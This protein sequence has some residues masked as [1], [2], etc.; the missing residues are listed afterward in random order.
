M[1]P[2]QRAAVFLKSYIGDAVMAQPI[3]APLDR[4][5]RDVK[6]VTS[7]VIDQV[8]FDPQHPREFL[9]LPRVRRF[10]EV[11]RQ[12]LFLRPYQ[13]EVAI[14]VN[15]SF[16]SAL[17]ARLA[18]I[19]I[20]VGHPEDGRR[21]LLTTSVPYSESDN[22]TVSY[23]DLIRVIGIDDAIELPRLWVS[24]EERARGR[25]FLAGARV[26]LQPGARFAAKRIPFEVT[27]EI[28]DSLDQAGIRSAFLGG[29]D[30]IASAEET[31]RLQRQ[32]SV[33]LVGRT[34]IRESLGVLS[35]LDLMVGSDTGLMHMAAAVHC[36][37]ITV[38]GPT[39]I[40]KWGHH[41]EPHVAVQAPE[42]VISN[43]RRELIWPHISRRLPV[44]LQTE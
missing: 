13:F 23:T 44:P 42:R 1:A 12:A 26:G 32:P 5:F 9:K 33:N 7:G 37:T 43:A 29:P 27:A 11:I 14:L 41:Y 2:R 31:I 17:T 35:N 38:F 19:K 39:P 30:E 15:H 10:A 4:H 21:A 36:P 18:G 16:R 8:L 34:S 28:A 24:S 22:E 25:Q 20:R 6:V 40:E 3:L